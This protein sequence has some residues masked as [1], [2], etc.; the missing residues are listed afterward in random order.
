LE[1]E[2]TGA[3]FH[4][5]GAG[6]PGADDGERVGLGCEDRL[7]LL[8]DRGGLFGAAEHTERAEKLAPFL[9][10][11]ALFGEAGTEPVEGEGVGAARV[12]RVAVGLLFL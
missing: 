6:G 1:P 7:G 10:R 4:D 8:P 5:T 11:A 9:G 3:S 12:L 2:K